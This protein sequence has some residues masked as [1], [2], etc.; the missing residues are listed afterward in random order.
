MSGM[1]TGSAF[2]KDRAEVIANAKGIAAQYF[3]I[4]CVEVELSNEE[5][6]LIEE[7]QGA[8]TTMQVMIFTADFRAIESH[9]IEHK[10]GQ[11]RRADPVR[12]RAGQAPRQRRTG[13][14]ARERCTGPQQPEGAQRLHDSVQAFD[15][16]RD[17]HPHWEQLTPYEISAMF[18]RAGEEHARG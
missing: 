7:H 17:D 18:W 2:G 14:S 15:K 10:Q 5:A 16:F 11:V 8:E 13:S 1:L 6:D 3:G 12:H 4:G 9:R